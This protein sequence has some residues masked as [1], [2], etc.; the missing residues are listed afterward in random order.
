MITR[1]RKGILTCITLLWTT[2]AAG[3]PYPFKPVRLLTFESGGSVDLVSRMIAPHLSTALGQNVV[4]ENRFSLVAIEAAARAQPDGYTLLVAGGTLWLAPLLQKVTFNPVKDFA[5][6][7]LLTRSVNVLVVHPSLPVKSAKELIALAKR[8]PGELNMSMEA[9]GS[10]VYLTAQLFKSMAGINVVGVA[11]RGTGAT[12]TALMGGEV[13]FAFGTPGSLAPHVKSGR[14]RA[15]AVTSAE[16]SVLFPG[17]PTIAAT[18]L[19]GYEVTASQG[20][21]APATT[22]DTIVRRLNEEIARILSTTELRHRLLSLGLDTAGSNATSAPEQFM[23][24]I[25]AETAKWGKV[26]QEAGI[27][28]D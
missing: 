13:Q 26:I 21:L 4:T 6:V 23:S 11:Y 2:A 15:L 7:A 25:Q 12:L 19:P 5:P 28:K 14:L 1:Q 18:G 10:S 9:A 8:R 16:P 3:Q 27:R 17:L 22:P 20:M 24:V